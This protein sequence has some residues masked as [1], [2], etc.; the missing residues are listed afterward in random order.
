MKHQ[1][2]GC[3][4]IIVEP[5]DRYTEIHYTISLVLYAGIF[6]NKTLKIKIAVQTNEVWSSAGQR[7]WWETAVGFVLRSYWKIKY[8][9]TLQPALKY[10][11][12][13]RQ[14]NGEEFEES[15]T[16]DPAKTPRKN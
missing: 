9:N 7:E 15:S 13:D 16:Y 4:L 6:H 3:E 11:L 2:S 5:G 1:V 8:G 12:E 14:Q 10:E